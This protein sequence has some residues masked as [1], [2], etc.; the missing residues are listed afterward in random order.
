MDHTQ[1]LPDELRWLRRRRRRRRPCNNEK[2]GVL[3]ISI[4]PIHFS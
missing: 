2:P 1:S 3:R 4:L